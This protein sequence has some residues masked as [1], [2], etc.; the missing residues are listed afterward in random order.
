MVKKMHERAVRRL[1]HT[2]YGKTG[3]SDLELQSG[4]IRRKELIKG[5]VLLILITYNSG[6]EL[7]HY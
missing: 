6:C 3:A 4:V 7:I 5:V 2:E 1:A